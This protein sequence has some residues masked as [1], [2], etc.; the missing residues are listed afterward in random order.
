MLIDVKGAA[1]KILQEGSRNSCF[2]AKDTVVFLINDIPDGDFPH[3]EF[4][5]ISMRNFYS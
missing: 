2:Q 1:R 4:P 3:N 5:R